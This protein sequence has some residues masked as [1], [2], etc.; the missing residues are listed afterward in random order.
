[1]EKLKLKKKL[2]KMNKSTRRVRCSRRQRKKE[3]GDDD[4]N[5]GKGRKVGQSSIIYNKVSQ[6]FSTSC[7]CGGVENLGRKKFFYRTFYL[8]KTLKRTLA[9]QAEIESWSVT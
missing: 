1:M 4:D 8:T 6:S 9:S 2:F 5:D 3:F 7:A